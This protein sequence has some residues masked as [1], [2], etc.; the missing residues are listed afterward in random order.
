MPCITQEATVAEMHK[1]GG[2]AADKQ[3]EYETAGHGLNYH[4]PAAGDQGYQF[5]MPP[6]DRISWQLHGLQRVSA[7]FLDA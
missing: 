6:G 2:W 5:Y 7:N 3:A 1:P 4:H